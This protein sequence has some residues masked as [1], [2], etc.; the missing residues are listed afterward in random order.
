MTEMENRGY[1]TKKIHP[2]SHVMAVARDEA[3]LIGVSDPR[4]IGTS[5]GE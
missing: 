5:A 2:K 3:G 4:D 1:K